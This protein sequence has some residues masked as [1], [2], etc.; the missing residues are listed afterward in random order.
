MEEKFL[1][2]VRDFCVF[3]SVAFALFFFSRTTGI[4]GTVEGVNWLDAQVQTDGSIANADDIATAYQSTA[5]VLRAYA[6]L[7]ITGSVAIGARQFIADEA[8]QNTEYLARRLLDDSDAGN[9]DTLL[10]NELLG[11]QNVNGGWGDFQGYDSTVL[12][13][14]FAL[15]VLGHAGFIGEEVGYALYYLSS[16]QNADGGWSDGVNGSSVYT[17]A[18]VLAAMASY[19]GLYV[20]NTEIA[21]AQDYVLAQQVGGNHWDETFQSALALIGLITT[22]DDLTGLAG[23]LSALR[24]AQLT[25][26]SWESQVYTTALALR[27]LKLSE[28]TP[29]TPGLA[30]IRGTLIDG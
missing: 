18:Q 12:D 22:T 4:A 14:A 1:R 20:L 5:E 28:A 16:K 13:T 10:F 29:A 23:N 21:A 19:Q 7:G 27:A 3:L 9:T 8:F 6:A 25:D 2:L 30:S 24:A 26:G 11:R 17:T 15:E